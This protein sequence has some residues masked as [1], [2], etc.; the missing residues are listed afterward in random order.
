MGNRFLKMA[1]YKFCKQ[2]YNYNG[3]FSEISKEDDKMN[4]NKWMV[5]C[6]EFDFN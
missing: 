3:L 4:M 5:F 2:A 6:K 1:F